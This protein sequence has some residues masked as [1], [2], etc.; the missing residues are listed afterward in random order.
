MW[1]VDF[2]YVLNSFMMQ[3]RRIVF[4][5]SRGQMIY[6]CILIKKNLFE[7]VFFVFDGLP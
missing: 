5:L 3:V 2:G 7:I 1:V 6:F 4:V